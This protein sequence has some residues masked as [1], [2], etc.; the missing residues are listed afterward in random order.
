MKD[1]RNKIGKAL[2]KLTIETKLGKVVVA[3]ASVV[4]IW[5]MAR[6]AYLLY[7]AVQAV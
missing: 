7:Q 6:M 5:S 2:D 3:I 1:M 4:G